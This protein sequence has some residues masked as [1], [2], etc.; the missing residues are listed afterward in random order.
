M[1]FST[2]E[3]W[4]TARAAQGAS[5]AKRPTKWSC[6]SSSRRCRDAAIRQ[7]CDGTVSKRSRSNGAGICR[8]RKD[9][10]AAVLFV[11][12]A[13]VLLVPLHFEFVAAQKQR[14]SA[15][16]IRTYSAFNLTPSEAINVHPFI[17]RFCN[18]L[19]L[20]KSTLALRRV[21]A[22]RRWRQ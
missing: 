18:G 10:T 6:C 3:P 4:E 22:V 14:S 20:S 11:I 17:A 21:F 16:P 12:H 15:W 9:A 2:A 19:C 7:R 1:M 13:P 8:P 5:G